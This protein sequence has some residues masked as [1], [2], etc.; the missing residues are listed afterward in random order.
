MTATVQVRNA[1]PPLTPL[2][3]LPPLHKR[4]TREGICWYRSFPAECFGP[5]NRFWT[6]YKNNPRQWVER[7]FSPHKDG[8]TWC[9]QQWL[10]EKGCLTTVAMERLARLIDPTV[11]QEMKLE[12]LEFA[13]PALPEALEAKLYDYQRQPARQLLRALTNGKE[14]WGYPGAVDLSD[15]GCHAKGQLIRMADGTKKRVED[16]VVG[17]SVAGL[18]GPQKVT[19]LCRGTETMVQVIPCCDDVEPWTVNLSHIMTMWER[20]RHELVDI[21]VLNV[22][23]ALLADDEPIRLPW[24]MFNDGNGGEPFTYGCSLELL[25]PAD[26]YGFSLDGDGRFFLGCGTVTHNTGKTA[27]SMAAALAT[28]REIGVLCPVVGRAGWERMFRHFG[29]E[30]RF[31]ETYEAVRGGWRPEIVSKRGDGN[32]WWKKPEDLILILD[33]AQAVRHDTSLTFEVC[34]NAIRQQIPMV[35]ASATIATSPIE[36]RFAGRI[37]G[38]HSGSHFDFERFLSTH[39]CYEQGRTWKWSGKNEFLQRIH[40]R[41]F[42]RRGCRVRKEDLGD[43]CPET[44]IEVLTLDVDGAEEIERHAKDAEE[45]FARL[46]K[47]G[48]PE[49]QIKMRENV[50]RM[51]LWQRTEDA[52]VEA[53]AARARRDIANGRSVAIFMNFDRTRIK[54]AKLLGNAP[55]F[56]GGQ[57]Q[58]LRA[59][60][61]AEFQACRIHALVSNIKAGG[62]SVSLHDTTGERPRSAY[63]FPTDRVVDMVQASGRVDRVGG[64]SVSEQWIP[65]VVGTVT[66]R[67]VERTRRKMLSIGTINDGKDAEARF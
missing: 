40:G 67:M 28:G 13:C 3:Q 36:M 29:A 31:L 14:E 11:Q 52:L 9:V 60:L 27:M 19:S 66:E 34:D 15:M 18:N 55:G 43:K 56:H 50:A 53:V 63:I 32:F 7:G 30:P 47:S 46:R 59:K 49:S 21:P 58:H 41:L 16:I 10:T 23:F 39:G 37:T 51:A 44:V 6:D 57:P 25:P 48:V 2:R 12:D 45:L 4:R 5:V 33:E 1:D 22:L 17:E 61:E 35:I 65:C 54:M 62:A 26:F 42:P 24:V 64:Q 20:D 38:L 8:T